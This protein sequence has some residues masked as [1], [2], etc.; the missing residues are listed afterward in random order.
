VL[1]KAWSVVLAGVPHGA[2]MRLESQFA[3]DET[4]FADPDRLEQVFINVLKNSAE[5]LP[6]PGI[7]PVAIGHDERGQHI[8]ITDNGPG[9][10]EEVLSS[11]FVRRRTTKESGH[12]LG[13]LIIKQLVEA[14]GGQVSISSEPAQ[15][16]EVVITLPYPERGKPKE[17]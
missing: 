12:G 17:R 5:A 9:I 4:V 8:R 13:L 2:A 1:E 7:L 10:S 11:L 6:G 3:P 15:G 14:H 16:T